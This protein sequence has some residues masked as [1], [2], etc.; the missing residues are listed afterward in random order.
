MKNKRMRKSDPY[1]NPVPYTV[2]NKKGNMITAEKKGHTITRN[3]S[4]FKKS[5]QELK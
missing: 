4:Y 2:T 1:Y 3:S 5:E